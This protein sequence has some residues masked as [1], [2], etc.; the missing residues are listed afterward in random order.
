MRETGLWRV[1]TETGSIYLIDLDNMTVLRVPDRDVEDHSDLRRDGDTLALLEI[2][3]PAVGH[4]MVMVLE[5]LGAGDATVR[6]TSL[7]TEIKELERA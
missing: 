3:E 5:P 6:R 2:G 1:T 4:C 7:V